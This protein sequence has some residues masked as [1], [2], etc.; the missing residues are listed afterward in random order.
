LSNSLAQEH[1]G[2]NIAAQELLASI[3]KFARPFQTRCD[4]SVSGKHLKNHSKTIA[5]RKSGK[6]ALISLRQSKARSR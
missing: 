1:S 4:S 6:F 2:R 5:Y 3:F